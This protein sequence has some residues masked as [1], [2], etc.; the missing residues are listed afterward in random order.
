[1]KKRLDQ[2]EMMIRYL[3]GEVT[4]EEQLRLEEQVFNDDEGYQQLLALEDELKY[5]YAQGGLTPGQRKSF[6]QRFMTSAQDRQKVELAGAVLA[7]AYEVRAETERALLPARE[8]KVAWWRALG[9]LFTVRSPGMQ[10]AFGAA[11]MV[12]LVGGSWFMFRTV[13][14]QDR[15]AVLEA[16]RRSVGQQTAA[17]RTQQE[18]LH[19][20][21]AAQQKRVGDLEKQLSDRS[22]APSFLS[23]V[24]APGL[25]RDAEGP[26]RLVVPGDVGE[27][28]L[29]LDVKGKGVY[30]GYRAELQT[31]EGAQ[32]W[33]Q[34]VP[35][36]AVAVPAR[37]LAAGDYVVVLKGIT[38]QGELEPVGEY[39]FEVVRR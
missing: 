13:Q 31:L 19:Q 34:D 18:R 11:S 15:I 12:L 24:L 23:F 28:R 7:K 5:E 35:R 3:L 4:E 36:P 26:K 29:Q 9:N 25:V 33:S 10:F 22:T 39:Y 37:F 21:L 30:K 14:L 20:E 6:E 32:L 1:M 17:D 16:E 2:D 38:A 27:A 8:E